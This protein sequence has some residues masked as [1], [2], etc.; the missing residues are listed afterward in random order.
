MR[1]KCPHCRNKWSVSR[2]YAGATIIC[3]SCREPVG[4]A[5]SLPIGALILTIAVSSAIAVG[6]SYKMTSKKTDFD[7][8]NAATAQL[9]N[10][11]DA[12]RE[13]IEKF[14]SEFAKM[15]TRLQESAA[16]PIV[17]VANNYSRSQIVS[18][19]IEKYSL[20]TDDPNKLSQPEKPGS[21][22]DDINSLLVFDGTINRPLGPQLILVNSAKKANELTYSNFKYI[23]PFVLDKASV[24]ELAP[25]TNVSED[26]SGSKLTVY[27]VPDGQY[28]YKETI[29]AIEIPKMAN[30]YRQTNIANPP[31]QR[32]VEFQPQMTVQRGMRKVPQTKSRSAV[33]MERFQEKMQQRKTQQ[34][35]KTR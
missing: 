21:T 1:V 5:P 4:L 33:R 24:I 7:Q 11:I 3:P 10:K 19:K 31:K 35:T 27:V 28:E 9:Q 22:L 20:E 14:D 2:K 23:P 34:R 8:V 26:I 18:G 13:K 12:A 16:Q 6:I 15:Q 17:A 29:G 25:G 30:R 32:L